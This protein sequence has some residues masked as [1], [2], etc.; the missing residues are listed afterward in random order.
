MQWCFPLIWKFKQNI[1]WDLKI[2]FEIRFN[3]FTFSNWKNCVF[4]FK[5][6]LFSSCVFYTYAFSLGRCYVYIYI[7][8]Y[9]L[10]EVLIHSALHER[11]TV[12]KWNIIKF[13]FS[14][15]LANQIN[16]LAILLPYYTHWSTFKNYCFISKFR[17]SLWC[18]LK[19]L[20]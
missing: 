15:P 14:K 5:N 9:K 19:Q 20:T 17:I 12:Q 13:I 2:A 6:S 7:F 4:F 1:V 11:N 8:F 10:L 18:K 16:I 3:Y